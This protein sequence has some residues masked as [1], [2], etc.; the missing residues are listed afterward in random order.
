M[1]HVDPVGGVGVEE[2]RIGDEVSLVVP[3]E[4][5]SGRIFVGNWR[6]ELRRRYVCP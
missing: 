2:P 3:G 6:V 1:Q 4:H 5:V